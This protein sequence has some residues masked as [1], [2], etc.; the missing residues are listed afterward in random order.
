MGRPLKY[1]TADE[2]QLKVDEYFDNEIDKKPTITGLCHHLG[3]ASRQSLYDMK[4]RRELSY[5]AERA[6]LR[7]EME[8]E[9]QL[10][11]GGNVVGAIFALKNLGWQDNQSIDH[12]SKGDKISPINIVVKDGGEREKLKGLS[13]SI[14][15]SD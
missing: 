12:T 5:T 11:S 10:R 3:F 2:L 4:K 9:K 15:E 8:Y 6:V 14:N 1:K 13:D 7:I